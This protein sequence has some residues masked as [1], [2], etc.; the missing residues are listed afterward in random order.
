MPS[1]T[2]SERQRR[3][4]QHSSTKLVLFQRLATTFSSHAVT[5]VALKDAAPIRRIKQRW[6]PP[7]T[8]VAAAR[9]RGRQGRARCRHNAIRRCGAG[10]PLAAG[11]C[12][13]MELRGVELPSGLPKHLFPDPPAPSQRAVVRPVAQSRGCQR[14]G[15]LLARLTV[16][17]GLVRNPV[18]P[19]GV[20]SPPGRRPADRKRPVPGNVAP[21]RLPSHTT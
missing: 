8:G 3:T 21:A 10:P 13:A 5:T 11:L 14:L 7:R 9:P 19:R 6:T 15:Q 18:P 2:G 16:R 20:F 12:L 1:G 4:G 17:P